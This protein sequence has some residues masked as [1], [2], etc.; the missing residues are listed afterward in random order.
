MRAIVLP[1]AIAFVLAASGCQKKQN[2]EVTKQKGADAKEAALFTDPAKA[3]PVLAQRLGM[4]ISLSGENLIVK[5]RDSFLALSFEDINPEIRVVPKST[6]WTLTCGQF[7]LHLKFGYE[8]TEGDDG[9]IV[10]LTD[11]PLSEPQCRSLAP[12]VGSEITAL[13]KDNI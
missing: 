3:I 9:T 11:T 4:Q 8:S 13:T 12:S 1:F 2:S 7:G 5:Y 10:A 6:P